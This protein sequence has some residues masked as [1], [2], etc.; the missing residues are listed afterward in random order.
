V[1]TVAPW[2]ARRVLENHKHG[3]MISWT[4]PAKIGWRFLSAPFTHRKVIDD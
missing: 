1:E 2:L 3:A 4:N